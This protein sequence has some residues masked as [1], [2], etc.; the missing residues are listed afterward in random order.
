MLPPAPGACDITVPGR[1]VASRR[2]IRVHCVTALEPRD[3]RT[4]RGIRVTAP[5]RTMLD[6]AADAAPDELERALSESI[7]LGLARPA[8]LRALLARAGARRGVA[9]LRDLLDPSDDAARVTRSEAERRMLAL[10]RR[11][12]LPRPET[13]VR[14]GAHEVDFLWRN[15]R[16]V[17][18][19][20]GFR[21]HSSRRAFERDRLR[22]AELVAR[23]LRV[24]RV[25]WRQIVGAPEAVAARLAAVLAIG[26]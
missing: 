1:V 8:D 14:I 10:I 20:D 19:V 5:A 16:V 25:T 12:G 15:E 23:G 26:A 22:D 21:Y 11:A 17:L 6:T 24:I 7:A 13:N 2:G 18:E 9:T 4:H 3:V